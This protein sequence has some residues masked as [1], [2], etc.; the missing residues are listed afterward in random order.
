MRTIQL[1][2]I[3]L[4]LIFYVLISFGSVKGLLGITLPSNKRKV[5][6]SMFTFSAIIFISFIFLYVWP[7]TTRN[8]QDYTLHLIFNA[9]LTIDFVF[10]IPLSFSFLFGIFFSNTRKPLIYSMGFILSIGISCN[11]I[12]GSLFGTK[13]LVV[14]QVVLNLS[15]LP[16]SYNGFKILQ[17][18]DIHLGN[19]P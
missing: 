15:N 18:S 1:F 5:I 14:N 7:L 3:V 12:Y 10:K 19:F 4:F 17:I 9:I 6:L 13:E 11:V 8:T 16:V 2:F